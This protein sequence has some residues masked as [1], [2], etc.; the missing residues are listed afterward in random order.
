MEQQHK[1]VIIAKDQYKKSLGCHVRLLKADDQGQIYVFKFDNSVLASTET[2]PP[3]SAK[4]SC[5]SKKEWK[6]K[7]K[8]EPWFPTFISLW[9]G[10]NYSARFDFSL[11]YWRQIQL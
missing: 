3:K 7:Y 5:T 2:L 4:F 1:S 11:Q 9:M 6:C 8:L 10:K